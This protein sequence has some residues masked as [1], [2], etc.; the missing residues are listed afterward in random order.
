MAVHV[1][2]L[3]RAPGPAVGTAWRKRVGTAA[4]A[5]RPVWGGSLL[6]D[7]EGLPTVRAG[8]LE[9][10]RQED[11]FAGAGRSIRRP[12][13]LARRP[14]F[15]E[16]R[17]FKEPDALA[18]RGRRV[19]EGLSLDE[20]VLATARALAGEEDGHVR[21]RTWSSHA[22][23]IASVRSWARLGSGIDGRV[24][25]PRTKPGHLADCVR[26]KVN[27]ELQDPPLL[28]VRSQ[29][30][31]LDEPTQVG[32]PALQV[33]APGGDTTGAAT[34]RVAARHAPVRHAPT[35]A[36]N[37]A[38]QGNPNQ[39]NPVGGKNLTTFHVIHIIVGIWLVAAPL[40]GIFTTRSSLITNNIVVGAVIAL[41]NAWFLFMKRNMDVRNRR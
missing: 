40:L 15:H 13:G 32:R 23:G 33:G 22:K 25:I 29:V 26:E 39:T 7:E 6:P 24:T 3:G 38:E 14:A 18:P 28:G 11:R 9:L 19:A 21:R 2:V 41:Y 36:G 10:A 5:P 35:P 4:P 20:D 34:R 30:E 37:M 17:G 12:G 1:L 27:N 8:H 16:A 31:P